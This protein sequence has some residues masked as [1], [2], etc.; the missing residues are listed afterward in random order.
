MLVNPPTA[1]TAPDHALQETA[2]T[3]LVHVVDDEPTIQNLFQSISRM[4]SFEVATYGTARAFLDALDESRAGCLVLDLNLPDMT[5]LDVLRELSARHCQLPVVFMSGM[6]KVS[7]AVSALKLGSVDF[8]EKP[9]DIKTILAAVQRAISLDQ[10]RRAASQTQAGLRERFDRL[11]PREREVMQLVVR[12]AANKEVAA[13]L[14]L[15]PKTVEV[16]RANVMRKTEAE[17]LAE[18]VRMHML[19]EEGGA[20]PQS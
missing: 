8:V 9:F 13:K 3:S 2:M 15:S 17:S 12:G 18:L 20:A 14:G 4:A 1:G 7:E 19:V 10:Q 6:A 5:G 11:T 16:H